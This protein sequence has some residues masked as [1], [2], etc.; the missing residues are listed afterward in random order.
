MASTMRCCIS[1]GGLI[2]PTLHRRNGSVGILRHR[3]RGLF[4]QRGLWLAPRVGVVVA[5][6]RR[7]IEIGEDDRGARARR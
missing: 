7:T 5:E 2:G 1:G 3:R 6:L 4:W